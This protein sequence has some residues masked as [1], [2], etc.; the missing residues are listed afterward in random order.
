MTAIRTFGNWELVVVDLASGEK[1][2]INKLTGETRE[3]PPD[4]VLDILEVEN[5]KVRLPVYDPTSHRFAPLRNGVQ[6]EA[7]LASKPTNVAGP[8]DTACRCCCGTGVLEPD[9]G[10]CPLCDGVGSFE[11]ED[12]VS[13]VDLLGGSDDAAFVLLN[14]LRPSECENIIAQAEGFGFDDCNYQ[15]WMRITDRVSVMGE[16]L[17]ELLFARARPYLADVEVPGPRGIPQ[18]VKS[19]I[20]T[21]VGLNPCFRVCR[22]KP[23]GFFL[24][25]HDGGFSYSTEHRSLKTF[26]LYLND[27]FEGGPTVFYKESQKHYKPPDPAKILH[28]LRPERG[29]CLVFNSC[30]TH[31]G[32]L[33]KAGRKYLLRSEVMYRRVVDDD[34]DF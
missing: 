7:D 15:R 14:L 8:D 12:G 27:D 1:A 22:Y 32:G 4:E 26:M 11:S 5:S 31:D 2:Y 18:D 13:R 9:Q 34:D 33:L 25:H 29:S 10:V 24:P 6:V 28:E 19:G 17:A 23:G 20:W 3:A 16:D 30:L 21:P